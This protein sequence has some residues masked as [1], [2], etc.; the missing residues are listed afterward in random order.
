MALEDLNSGQHVLHEAYQVLQQRQRTPPKGGY[1]FSKNDHVS[2]KMGR[3]PPSLCKC[4]SNKNHWDKECPDFNT[5]L[6]RAKRSANLVEI[7]S[8]NKADK[9]YASAYSV[10]LNEKLSSQMINQAELDESIA[11]QGFKQA[12]SSSQ[13]SVGE[14]SKPSVVQAFNALKRV[15]I[16]EVEDKD[17]VAHLNKPKSPKHLLEETDELGLPK[18]ES[19]EKVEPNFRSPSSQ[20]EEA[21]FSP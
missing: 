12:S 18:G 15:T 14:V 6:E 8:D 9:A 17:W 1:P 7:W 5:Y 11:Q 3:L 19:T 16:V 21:E 10:L 4:C 2:T 13:S 20:P